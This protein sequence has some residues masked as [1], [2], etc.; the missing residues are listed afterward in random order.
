MNC[1]EACGP[2]EA[3]FPYLCY[4]DSSLNMHACHPAV[5]YLLTGFAGCSVNPEI[6]YGARKLARI[7]RLKK[8]KKLVVMNLN[9]LN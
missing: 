2:A 4:L 7:S 3:R 9:I 1:T 6:S 8:K 5:S